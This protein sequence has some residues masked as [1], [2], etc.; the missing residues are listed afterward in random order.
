MANS[1]QTQVL[2]HLV[3][4][5]IADLSPQDVLKVKCIYESKEG[6]NSFNSPALEVLEPAV[7]SQR[8]HQNFLQKATKYIIITCQM[9]LPEEGE[10]AAFHNTG[11]ILRKAEVP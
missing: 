6:L 2:F 11:H 1:R 7:I 8:P 9:P 10:Y 5:Y 4:S 3:H